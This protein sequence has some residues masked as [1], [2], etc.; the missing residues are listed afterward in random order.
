MIRSIVWHF[1]QIMYSSQYILYICVYPFFFFQFR[2][3]S[4][5]NFQRAYTT[6]TTSQHRSHCQFYKYCVYWQWD[7]RNELCTQSGREFEMRH[8]ADWMTESV[9]DK[10]RDNKQWVVWE[11]HAMHISKRPNEECEC[12]RGIP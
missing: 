10:M 2:L 5:V 6:T 7:E 4:H 12:E 8:G 9:N 3:S 1:N 11:R